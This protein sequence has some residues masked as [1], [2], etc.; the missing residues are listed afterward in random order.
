MNKKILSLV[1]VSALT[2]SLT[3]CQVKE[4][5]DKPNFT[6]ENKA[7]VD[8]SV[9]ASSSAG[10]S[11]LIETTT[12]N[13]VYEG[14][15]DNNSIEVKV[16]GVTQALRLRDMSRDQLKEL[17]PQ[18]GDSLKIDMF[19]DNGQELIYSIE[20]AASIPGKKAVQSTLADY[21]GQIDNN[22]IEV[23][24]E[25]GPI[26]MR[27]T[28]LAKDQLAS[29]KLQKGDV[30]KIETFEDDNGQQTIQLLEKSK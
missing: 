19:K 9:P 21:V 3:G 8:P 14:Q 16:D 27:L 22:S 1:L 7:Q 2:F 10:E 6:T 17:N 5:S 26:A 18:K 13:A 20:K 25:D 29:L 30:V 4:K 24:I 15:I 12:I 11:T 23:N 28:D